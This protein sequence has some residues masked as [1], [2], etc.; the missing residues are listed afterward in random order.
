[1]SFARGE[2]LWVDFRPTKG[3]EQDGR[4]PALVISPTPYNDVSSTILVCPITSNVNP[5]P[6]KVPLPEGEGIMGAVLVDQM[7]SIDPKARHAERAG[8]TVADAVMNE[9]TARLRTLLE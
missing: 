5:W 4:R 1:V 8:Q 9:I 7:K 6:W 2:I 3:R